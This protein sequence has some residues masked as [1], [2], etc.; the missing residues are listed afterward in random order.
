VGLELARGRKLDEIVASMKMVAE[1][2]KTT[3]ATVDL[4][5]RL[6]VDMPI[7]AQMFEMLNF[8]LPP[9]EAVRRLM[10]RTLKG[11]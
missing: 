1:G 3:N 5:Q 11:E 10:D 8:G 7:S 6:S 9:R 4:A 2:V